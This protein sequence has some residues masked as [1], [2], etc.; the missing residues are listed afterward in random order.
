M[1][2]W[3]SVSVVV[4]LVS[5][6]HQIHSYI[7]QRVHK[8]PTNIRFIHCALSMYI[9][10]RCMWLYFTLSLGFGFFSV[11]VPLFRFSCVYLQWVTAF[12]WMYYGRMLCAPATLQ[13][14]VFWCSLSS[15]GVVVVI[16]VVGVAVVVALVLLFWF[17][18][19]I[20]AYAKC[21]VCC[22]IR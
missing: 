10:W 1:S 6:F 8:R 18:L 15:V 20:F 19:G 21:Y 2:V 4:F 3:G 17:W 7:R 13:H 5:F 12:G 11:V 14:L 22:F 9:C 16:I